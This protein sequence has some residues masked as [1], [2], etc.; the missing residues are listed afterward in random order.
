MS[1]KDVI[2]SYKD[3]IMSYKD[4]IMSY[5]QGVIQ[6]KIKVGNRVWAPRIWVPPKLFL[7]LAVCFFTNIYFKLN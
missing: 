6:G 1:Y 5:K 2:M 4:V 3:V 7:D